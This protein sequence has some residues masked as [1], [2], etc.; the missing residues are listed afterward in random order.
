MNWK[1][2]AIMWTASLSMV[3]RSQGSHFCMCYSLAQWW[4]LIQHNVTYLIPIIVVKDNMFNLTLQMM[5]CLG[6][7]T[8]QEGRM[9]AP[10][11]P[12]T[13]HS[14]SVTSQ[15]THYGSSAATRVGPD[16]R[17]LLASHWLRASAGGI[18]SL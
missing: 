8:I 15:A 5:V 12:A 10:L 13:K 11:L 17:T 1:A 3:V 16:I 6:T 4:E 9:L 18:P 14:A 2:S 7:D